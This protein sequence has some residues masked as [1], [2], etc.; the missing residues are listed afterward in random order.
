MSEYTRSGTRRAGDDYQDAV[1]LDVLVDAL[2]HADRYASIE[3]EADGVGV[4]DD[5]CAV[6]KDGRLIL[7]QV[8]FSTDPLKRRR[9]TRLARTVAATRGQ[10]QDAALSATTLG[11]LAP[12]SKGIGTD[13]HAALETNGA[14]LG[15][16]RSNRLLGTGGA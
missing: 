7:K 2:E 6:L 13:T 3:V 4:L 12:S 5:V 9:G 10:T 8:K 1:A 15:S 11:R 14:D 16:P